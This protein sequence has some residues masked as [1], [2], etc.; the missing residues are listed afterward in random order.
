MKIFET[1]LIYPNKEND[2]YLYF[3]VDQLNFKNIQKLVFEIDSLK[4]HEAPVEFYF[5][6][7]KDILLSQKN[8]FLPMPIKERH[9][10]SKFLT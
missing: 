8:P 6:S 9:T 4:M 1:E 7:D 3:T 5:N 2:S 10:S